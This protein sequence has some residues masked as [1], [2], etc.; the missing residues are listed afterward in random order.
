M[1]TKEV[2]P[3]GV[4]TTQTGGRYYLLT[5]GECE[6]VEWQKPEQQRFLVA[7]YTQ[8]HLKHHLITTNPDIQFFPDS[9]VKINVLEGEEYN[10]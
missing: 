9:S 1:K 10:A 3:Y 5:G 4:L 8:P 7:T 6:P 2:V